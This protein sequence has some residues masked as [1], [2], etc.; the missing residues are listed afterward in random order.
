MENLKQ[1]RFL[2][3]SDEEVFDEIIRRIVNN[4]FKIFFLENRYYRILS[5]R[6]LQGYEYDL[7]SLEP[8]R[9][10]DSEEDK[11]RSEDWLN[12]RQVYYELQG[13]P[14][15]HPWEELFEKTWIDYFITWVL[16]IHDASSVIDWI[17]SFQKF[18]KNRTRTQ[19]AELLGRTLAGQNMHNYKEEY[20]ELKDSAENEDCHN[21]QCT[22]SLE[23]LFSG[24]DKEEREKV[25]RLF[26]EYMEDNVYKKDG[27]VSNV[28]SAALTCALWDCKCFNKYSDITEVAKAVIEYMGWEISQIN[29]ESFIK[30]LGEFRGKIS[31]EEDLPGKNQKLYEDFRDKLELFSF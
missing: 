6:F 9:C 15:H 30:E 10:W 12:F 20:T 16:P 18:S 2:S 24:K 27:K 19:I 29:K 1:T 7:D 17:L 28:R 5:E 25:L 13:R 3:L 11:Q 31:K 4:H 8:V 23:K 14:C 26:K 22:A 21:E